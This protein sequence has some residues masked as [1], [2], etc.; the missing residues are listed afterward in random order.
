MTKVPLL[1][2]QPGRDKVIPT[3]C[4]GSR[5]FSVAN[6][7]LVRFLG[8][9]DANAG[10]VEPDCYWDRE[11]AMQARCLFD[12]LPNSDHYIETFCKLECGVCLGPDG[13]FIDAST[14]CEFTVAR[15]SAERF[16]V[17]AMMAL[18]PAWGSNRNPI[19]DAPLRQLPAL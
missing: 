17:A 5:G 19:A 1:D 11:F 3:P 8:S 18:L 9:G 15:F 6:R 7:D 12:V 13:M 4:A 14:F 2:I 16:L 10:R